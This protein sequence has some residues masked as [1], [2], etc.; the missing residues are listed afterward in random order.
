MGRV[1]VCELAAW[2]D[3]PCHFPGSGL[4]PASPIHRPLFP[5]S[6]VIIR[7]LVYL[8]ASTAPTG[9]PIVLCLPLP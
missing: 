8:Q 1:A 2:L 3:F 5:G 4:C 7:L 9:D 6:E